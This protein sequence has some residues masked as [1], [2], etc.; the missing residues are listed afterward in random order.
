[1]EIRDRIAIVTGAGS[2][3][4]RATS[5]ALSQAGARGVVLA[6]VDEEALAETAPP[7]EAAGAAALCVRCDV[8]RAAD[9]IGLLDIAE[10]AFGRV[11]ILHNNAGLSS[12][13]PYWPDISLERIEALVDVNLKGVLLGTR[14]GVER[15]RLSGGGAIVNTASV[16][17]HA[18]LPPEAI[19][20]AT[21]AGVA[22]FTK[23]CAQLAGSHGVRVNCVCPGVTETPMLRKTGT[24]GQMADYLEPVYEA[25]L[26]LA[27]E[28]IAAAVI[29]LI[30][31]EKAAGEVVD[32]LNEARA[33]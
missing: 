28:A 27:P 2:G 24:D 11:D 4:G 20:C 6:D 33:S 9:W 8:R 29:A 5:I 31:D 14:L 10:E 19:Y 7:V 32:V 1:M 26:P 15:M 21:K 17:A 30:E 3:I 13:T 16:A 18:P 23:C 22:M 25:L 12:G